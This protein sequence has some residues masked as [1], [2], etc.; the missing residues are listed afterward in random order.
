LPGKNPLIKLTYRPPNYEA[1]LAYLRT[2]ITPNDEFFVR[3][4]HADIPQVDASQW[5]LYLGGEGAIIEKEIGLAELKKLPVAEVI[6]VCECA[7]NRHGLLIPHAPGVQ[8]GHGAV[9]CARWTGARLKDLLDLVG[10]KENAVEIVFDGADGPVFDK[11]PDFVKSLPVWK[12]LEDTTLV[13]YEMN[14]EPLPHWNGFPAR[15]VV[16]GWAGPTG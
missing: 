13:A 15:I 3:Y 7:G 10:L 1:P 12:A 16:P 6:A 11:T 14:G 9:G 5:R 2:A 4:H 8:W